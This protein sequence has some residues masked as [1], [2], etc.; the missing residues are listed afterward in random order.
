[1]ADLQQN[2]N[3]LLTEFQQLQLVPEDLLK[4]SLPDQAHLFQ[5]L[6]LFNSEESS[7]PPWAV[8]C[9]TS[10]L[11]LFCSKVGNTLKFV[12]IESVTYEPNL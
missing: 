11:Q 7:Y 6:F 2:C 4:S 8:A 3:T 5:S 9:R 10:L 12:K 1:M